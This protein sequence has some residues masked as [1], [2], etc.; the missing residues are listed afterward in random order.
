MKNHLH[1]SLDQVKIRNS[2]WLVFAPVALLAIFTSGVQAQSN[3]GINAV[4]YSVTDIPPIKSDDAY[5]QCSSEI[6]NNINRNFN[7]EPVNGCPEDMF[8]AHYTGFITLPAHDTIRLWVAADD[9]GTIKIGS[10]EWGSWNDKGCTAEETDALTLDAGVPLALDAWYYENGGGT[11]FMLAWQIDNGDWE[12]VPDD[13]FTRTFVST[14][15]TTSTTTSSTTTTVVPTTTTTTT[16]QPVMTTTTSLPTTTTTASSSTTTL[17]IAEPTTTVIETTTTTTK[18]IAT[19]LPEATTTTVVVETSTT[20]SVPVEAVTTLIEANATAEQVVE[21]VTA[22]IEQGISQ[23]E[24][25]ELATD[26]KVLASVNAEQAQ[27]IFEAIDIDELTTEQAAELVSAVQNAPTEVKQAFEAAVNVFAGAV[28][29]YVPIGSSVPVSSRRVLIAVTA[30]MSMTP[31][32][33]RKQ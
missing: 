28:D 16:V 31:V 13:A 5:Q 18:P 22:I 12:I 26:A 2:H 1:H 11:C 10:Y 17:S 23:D 33:T 8:M 30:A 20:T 15:S 7:G 3:T 19:T 21:A 4:Y 24:A 27:E 25:T 32:P 29:T 9:G 6:E 14:T